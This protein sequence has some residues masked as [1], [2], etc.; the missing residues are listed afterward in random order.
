MQ[1]FPT[2]GDRLL[3]IKGGD[4]RFRLVHSGDAPVTAS[5]LQIENDDILLSMLARKRKQMV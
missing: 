3:G 2:W 4:R 5:K 1:N